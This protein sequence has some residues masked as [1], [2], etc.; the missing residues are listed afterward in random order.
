MNIKILSA[1]V[2]LTTGCD[3]IILKTSLPCPYIPDG[4]SSQPDLDLRFDA[5]YD[6]GIDYCYKTLTITPEVI[7][8]RS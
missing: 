6:T 5:T 3:K 4:L 8:S 2:L 7:D 1:T